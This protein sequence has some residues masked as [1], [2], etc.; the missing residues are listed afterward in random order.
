MS[1]TETVLEYSVVGM[2]CDHCVLS[3]TEE[4][5]AVAGVE[6]VAVELASGRMLVAGDASEEA[7]REAVAEAGYEVGS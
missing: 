6:R 3:L 7:V 2:S 1:Q 5:G 4:V